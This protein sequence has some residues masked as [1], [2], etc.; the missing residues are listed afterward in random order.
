MRS[1]WELGA[2]HRGYPY[3]TLRLSKGTAGATRLAASYNTGDAGMLEH[4]KLSDQTIVN[5]KFN[6]NSQHQYA[7]RAILKNVTIGGTYANPYAG[8][9]L[10][11]SSW[12]AGGDM[13]DLVNGASGS[14]IM[15]T[16]VA[17][18]MTDGRYF[19][20]NRGLIALAANFSNRTGQNDDRS[21][22]ELIGKVANLLTVRQNY[23]TVVV[24]GR[25]VRDL[26]PTLGATAGER[27]RNAAAPGEVF[28]IDPLRN[29]W[30]RLLGEE[31][32][33]AILYRD[34]FTNV[35]RVEQLIPLR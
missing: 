14:G 21:Q 18:T 11:D 5:G 16:T 3:Q 28:P 23:F 7:W 1:L 30:V 4:V 17:T 25:A 34:A 13:F 19:L 2:I 22:E 20:N 27:L 8:T 31:R 24:V 10:D 12:M 6:A 15:A 32:Y 35:V 29:H 26:G 33:V 9:A